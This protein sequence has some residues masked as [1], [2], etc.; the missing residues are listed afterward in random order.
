[1]FR[2]PIDDILMRDIEEEDGWAC[3]DCGH[4]IAPTMPMRIPPKFDDPSLEG[5]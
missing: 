5:W 1:V 3:P 2:L 4:T